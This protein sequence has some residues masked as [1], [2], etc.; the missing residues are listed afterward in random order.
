MGYKQQTVR[1]HYSI[2]GKMNI[3]NWIMSFGILS[4]IAGVYLASGPV[5]YH[6]AVGLL[7]FDLSA[8]TVCIIYKYKNEKP[9]KPYWENKS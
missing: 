3:D 2:R 8:L 4:V 5:W 9:I 1:P 6:Y 7:I